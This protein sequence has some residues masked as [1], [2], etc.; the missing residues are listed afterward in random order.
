MNVTLLDQYSLETGENTGSE[1]AQGRD[2]KNLGD[3]SGCPEGL[4]ASRFNKEFGLFD[5]VFHE[6]SDAIA[7][8]STKAENDDPLIEDVNQQFEIITGQKIDMVKDQ[9]L[10]SYI[11]HNKAG[12][13]QT[14]IKDVIKTRRAAILFCRWIC[15]DGKTLDVNLT[16]R[17]FDSDGTCS[18]FIC[19]L[20]NSKTEDN[21][22]NEAAKDT[23]KKLLAAMHHNFRTPLNGILGYSEVI[24]SEMLGPIGKESYKDYAQDIHG[25]GQELLRLIDTLLE[26]KELETAEFDLH[27]DIFKISHMVDQ[28]LLKMR[29]RAQNK[30]INL[31]S[32]IDDDLPLLKGDRSR[33]QQVVH[34]LLS[35]ALKFTLEE[36]NISLSAEMEKDGSCMIKCTDDGLGMM[37]QELTKVFCHDTH[38]ANIYSNP[39]TGIGFGLSYVKQLVEKHEG[40]VS[41]I[42]AYGGGTTV[43]LHLP[44]HRLSANV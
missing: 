41:I 13:N 28:C 43:I 4:S 23:K 14:V 42:S 22:R 37:P 20:R 24:M 33:L 17:P 12:N 30:N 39:T 25:A 31:Q 6:V 26:L 29:D 38:L 3:I 11:D 44:A 27:E 2:I 8:I 10:F 5:S 18:R 19:I 35:N 40:S 15:K 9:N 36:G 34:S 21:V 1:I 16:I 32:T 7:I